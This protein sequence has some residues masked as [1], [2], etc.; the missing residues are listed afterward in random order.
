MAHCALPA[1]YQGQVT[2]ILV[3]QSAD[4]AWGVHDNHG[5]DRRCPDRAEAMRLARDECRNHP[6]SVVLAMPPAC[7]GARR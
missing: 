6:G 1:R 5:L 2:I 4:G 3:D 7:G